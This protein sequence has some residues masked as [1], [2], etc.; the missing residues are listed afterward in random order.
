MSLSLGQSYRI[1][2]ER[3]RLSM[4]SPG[5]NP[6]GKEK[7]KDPRAGMIPLAELRA[8]VAELMKEAVEAKRGDHMKLDILS[9]SR[10]GR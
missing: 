3:P 6:V 10:T 8:T 7:E 5:N 9:T 4:A 2:S 1:Q